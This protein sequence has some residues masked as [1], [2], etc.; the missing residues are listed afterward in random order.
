MWVNEEIVK[1][2]VR[3]MMGVKNYLLTMRC[4]IL[5]SLVDL[6]NFLCTSRLKTNLMM[7]LVTWKLD[8]RPLTSSYDG[9]TNELAFRINSTK[10]WYK[11]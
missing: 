10:N 7:S 5:G 2:T 6:I 1:H 9:C 11:C 3:C 8:V 4:C